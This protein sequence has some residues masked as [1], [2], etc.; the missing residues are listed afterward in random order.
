[1]SEPSPFALPAHNLARVTTSH[2]PSLPHSAPSTHSSKS[3]HAVSATKRKQS[4]SRNGTLTQLLALPPH[5]M[6]ITP[7]DTHF[8]YL[9]CV[10]CKAKRLK[11]DE[12]KPTC[13]QCA[14]R[15][16]T[17]GG[18]RKDFKW[19]AF[20][21]PHAPTRQSAKLKKGCDMYFCLH[22]T[23][24]SHRMQSF[25][26]FISSYALYPAG[27]PS[28]TT[29]H[30][31]SYPARFL[32]PPAITAGFGT[33]IIFC[34]ESRVTNVLLGGFF[35]NRPFRSCGAATTLLWPC[36]VHIAYRVA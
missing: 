5:I 14:R 33:I 16:V 7:A 36:P 30:L 35:F 26:F 9:G 1:M 17:C 28:G 13:A 11:C 21:E 12:T 29:H 31:Q 25:R 4:K 15:S 6:L 32:F 27:I 23:S 10:T 19:R 20:E 34:R 8:A 2:H 3:S 24:N 18:Y 22:R